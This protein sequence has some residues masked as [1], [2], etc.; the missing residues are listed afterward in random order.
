[1][2]MFGLGYD[3]IKPPVVRYFDPNGISALKYVF[4]ALN[5][6]KI[7]DTIEI[8][9]WKRRPKE[10]VPGQTTAVMNACLEE[11]NT[12]DYGKK[13]KRFHK[14]VMRR[15]DGIETHP[16]KTPPKVGLIGE[17]SM[18]RDKTLNQ[19]V[20]ELLGNLGVEV[21]N[22]FLL[23]A[24]MGNIFKISFRNKNTRKF[25][26]RIAAPYLDSS[27]GGHALDSVAHTIKCA[28]QGFDGMV[29]LCPT[30]CMPE[31]SVRPI[32]RRI[33]K[34][35]DIPVLQ[36]SFDEHTSAVGLASRLEAFVDV[37]ESRRCRRHTVLLS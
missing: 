23:G 35:L 8:A 1:M 3:G 30:G 32:L 18:L 29:H 15:F 36:C 24:E 25:L 20:E 10:V 13:I 34:D 4:A 14:E 19:N 12:M 21:R 31:V 6:I 5:K 7:I 27:V 2:R 28:K 11:L 37:L 17:V 9:T 33:S 22:Y 16:N 26:A